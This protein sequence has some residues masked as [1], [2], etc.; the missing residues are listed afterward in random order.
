MLKFLHNSLSVYGFGNVRSVPY[1]RAKEFAAAR[2]FIY[3]CLGVRGCGVGDV[4][5]SRAVLCLLL[6]VSSRVGCYY[7]LF[8][9]FVVALGELPAVELDFEAYRRAA[10]KYKTV[11]ENASVLFRTQ[12]WFYY[13]F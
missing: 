10:K 12:R 13:C 8:Y 2:Q 5:G 4:F 6:K 11:G 3:I 7:V 9:A 1:H